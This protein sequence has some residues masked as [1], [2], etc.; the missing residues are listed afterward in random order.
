MYG[1]GVE[2]ER[3][4]QKLV[5]LFWPGKISAVYKSKTHWKTV[6]KMRK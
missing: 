3:K 4:S 6:I 5:F 1:L 2:C